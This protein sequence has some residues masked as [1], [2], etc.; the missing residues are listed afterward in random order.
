M[1]SLAAVLAALVV[2]TAACSDDDRERSGPR[3]IPTGCGLPTPEASLDEADVPAGWLTEGA[4]LTSASREKGRLDFGLNLPYTV[5]EVL[6]RYR[7]IVLGLG[8]TVVNVDNEIFEAEVFFERAR[9]VGTIQ[10]RRSTCKNASVA[11]VSVVNIGTL[12]SPPALTP[13]PGET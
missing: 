4:E 5:V 7:E 2:A 8:F 3:A 13:M 12:P 11:F 9:R 10:I 1:R 6:R